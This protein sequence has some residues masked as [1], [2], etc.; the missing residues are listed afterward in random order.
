MKT[1]STYTKALLASI[2]L[3]TTTATFAKEIPLQVAIVKNSIGS[4]DILSGK[5][6]SGIS[7]LI[8]KNNPRISYDVNTGLCVAYLKTNKLDKAETSCTAA[9][10]SIES[11]KVMNSLS[12]FHK[13]ISYNNRAISRYLNNNITGAIED[14]KT[15]SLLDNNDIVKKNTDLLMAKI[16]SS[17][18]IDFIEKDTSASE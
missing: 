15:A 17:E 11:S 8:D 6:T 10:K 5:F 16:S 14:M 4:N 18:D 13:S 1:K 3:M 9:I 7:K 12:D 2:A